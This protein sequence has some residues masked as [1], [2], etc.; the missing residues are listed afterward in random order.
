M[1]L[2]LKCVEVQSSFPLT[3]LFGI[4]IKIYGNQK[5]EKENM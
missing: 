2:Q 4:K 3:F 1:E 5:V